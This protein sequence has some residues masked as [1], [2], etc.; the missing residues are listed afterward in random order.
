MRQTTQEWHK[1]APCLRLKIA[2]GRQSVKYS[3]L[4]FCCKISK[5]LKGRPFGDIKNFPKKISQCRKL[6]GDPFVSA[7]LYVTLEKRKI[8]LVQFPMPNGSIRHH[9]VW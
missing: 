6:K 3:F 9:K 4:T 2:Q 1:S 5:K 8:C 7:A